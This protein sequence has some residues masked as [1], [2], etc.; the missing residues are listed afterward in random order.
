M[1]DKLKKINLTTITNI[2]KASLIGVIVSILLV[3]LFA[4]VLKFVDLS[5]GTISLID[6]I[7]KVISVLI[8]VIMLNKTNG[9]GLL[10]K[11]LLAGATYSII[12]FIVFSI[13]NGGLSFGLG[14]LTDIAFSALV[15]GASAILLNI[16]KKK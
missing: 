5:S 10:V 13:L 11:G 2:L 3:L 9:E 14:V 1:K 7:I 4:F 16:I 15:G 6:Q 12:T 8:A